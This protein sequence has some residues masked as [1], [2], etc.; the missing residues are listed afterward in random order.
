MKGKG[1]ERYR[2]RKEGRIGTKKGEGE[3]VAEGGKESKREKSLRKEEGG[4]RKETGKKG[5]R[6]RGG[7]E[8]RKE[9]KPHFPPLFTF[10]L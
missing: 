5:G 8:R 7:K 3:R 10:R 9:G 1:R 6:E 2:G 4:K